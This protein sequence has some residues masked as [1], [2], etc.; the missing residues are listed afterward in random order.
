MQRDSRKEERRDKRRTRIR[1]RVR[2]NAARPRLAVFRSL[3][4]IYAQA[5]DDEQGRTVAHAS[6][7]DGP[8]KEKDRT[9]GNLA[10]ARE[11]GVRIAERLQA[12]GLSEVVFDRGGYPYHG[13]IK[14]VA[15]AAREKGLRF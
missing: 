8:G 1:A 5:I 12:Q 9:G 11:V 3:N 14:A 6:S 15:E 4:H 2:G 10:A 13:R 7:L